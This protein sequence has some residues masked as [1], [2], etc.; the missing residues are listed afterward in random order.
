MANDNKRKLYDALSQDYDMGSY[1]QFCADLNDESKRRKLYNTTSQ[2]YDL[3]TWDSFSNQLGYGKVVE[4]APAQ[5][6]AP[7]EKVT[8]PSPAS[9]QYFKLRRGGKD[10]TVS[11]D[12]VNA[13]GGLS[14]WVA[15]NPGAPVRVYMQGDNFNGHVDL[16][17]AHDRNKKNGY[18]Y[19]TVS[20]PITSAPTKPQKPWKP[21]T[22]QR[23][24]M[25]KQLHDMQ[26][27]NDAMF[28]EHRERMENIREYHSN[29]RGALTGQSIESK[30]VYNPETGKMEKSY[31]TPTGDRTTN[32]ALADMSAYSYRRAMAAADMSVGAQIRRTQSE[33]EELK[34]QLAGSQSRVHEEWAED[35]KKNTA[36][37]AAVLAADTYVPRQMS[38]KENSALRVAIRQKEEALKDLYE[39]RDRQIGKDVGFWRGFGRTVKDIR[40]WDFGMGDMLDA[41]T[42]LNAD[43]YSAPDR[44]K[45]VRL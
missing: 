10:F 18:K 17:V 4:S 5:A 6:Q 19:T 11:T 20:S 36:P 40:T 38:D 26:R 30:P 34:A 42:M 25:T 3:G 14:G 28:E 21:T 2:E 35:Y 27:R 1:E 39:E 44:R 41:M 9:A 7:A 23:L 37:L 13:A 22:Q 43:K 29:S 12:E 45:Q 15:A 31:V 24:A 8:P 33:L 16:S 32:K